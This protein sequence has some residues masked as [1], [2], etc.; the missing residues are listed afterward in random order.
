AETVLRMRLVG[1]NP[2][3]ES[4]ALDPLPGTVNYFVGNDPSKWR[5]GLTSY[6]TVE[7]RQ[8]YDGIS[9][10]YHSSESQ[11]LEY[12]F[13][14]EPGADAGAIALDF[15]GQT[16]IEINAQGNLVLHTDAGDVIEQAPVIYQDV[17]D[18]REAVDGG[19]ELGAD[20]RVGFRVGAYDH[21][22]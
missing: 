12:D 15:Q 8:G 3:P 20:G 16:G 21:G 4:A 14:V 6:G 11:E 7:Y 13:T 1:A 22:R 19:Y 9:L 17:G 2:D 5:S 18:V 10:D